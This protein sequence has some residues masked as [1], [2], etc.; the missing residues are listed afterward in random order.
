[1]VVSSSSWCL[2]L[3]STNHNIGTVVMHDEELHKIQAIQQ[4]SPRG[5]WTGVG[6]LKNEDGD[7]RVRG[8]P[9][10]ESYYALTFLVLWRHILVGR[11]ASTT[12]HVARWMSNLC[13]GFSQKGDLHSELHSVA[14]LSSYYL[15]INVFTTTIKIRSFITLI[16]S[17]RKSEPL[18]SEL[19][20]VA[21]IFVLSFC[22][23]I[24]NNF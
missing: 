1:V 24:Y 17:S 16:G 3:S 23:Y 20:S 6:W 11:L 21:F 2:L 12:M 15:S 8:R 18:H 13:F 19:Y 7:G 5:S 22:Q 4:A 10:V 9:S 14:L